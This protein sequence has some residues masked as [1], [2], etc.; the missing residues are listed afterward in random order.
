MNVFLMTINGSQTW[1]VLASDVGKATSLV[2][3]RCRELGIEPLK[4]KV[5]TYSGLTIEGILQ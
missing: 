4:I 2:S 1:L 5:Q 3:A